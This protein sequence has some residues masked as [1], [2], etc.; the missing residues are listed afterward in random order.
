MH[1]F[2]EKESFKFLLKL[3]KLRTLGNESQNV[4]ATQTALNFSRLYSRIQPTKMVKHR[5]CTN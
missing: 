5:G 2:E 1:N 3:R 4:L